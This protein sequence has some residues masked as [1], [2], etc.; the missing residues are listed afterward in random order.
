MR[1]S[2]SR[3]SRACSRPASRRGGTQSVARCTTS[4]SAPSAICRSC[5]A[6]EGPVN[7]LKL[8]CAAL[9][10]ALVVV[11]LAPLPAAAQAQRRNGQPERPRLIVMLV[12]DQ[13]RGDY[14]KEYGG[15][16]TAGL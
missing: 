4:T 13:L 15:T 1:S 6:E 16:F 12:V 7:R 14:L 8:S 9:A 5:G 3:I 2:T 10:A 11:R